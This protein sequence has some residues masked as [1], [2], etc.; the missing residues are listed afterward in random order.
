MLVLVQGF[1][2]IEEYMGEIWVDFPPARFLC[3]LVSDDPLTGFLIIN[4]GLFGFGLWCWLFPVR[5][6][7]YYAQSLVWFWIALGLINGMGHTLWSIIQ[8]AY[9]PGLWTAPILFLIATVLIRKQ[10]N[11]NSNV[12]QG[13]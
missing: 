4:I 10:L 13:A 2:S 11:A 8:R 7:Y 12:Q 3:S 6:Q 5:G 1:H 9:T